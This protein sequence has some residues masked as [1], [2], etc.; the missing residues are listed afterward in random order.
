MRLNAIDWEDEDAA[1]STGSWIKLYINLFELNLMMGVL[2]I[3]FER[4]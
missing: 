4:S 2:A 1:R 3:V